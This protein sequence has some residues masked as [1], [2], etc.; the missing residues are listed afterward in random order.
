V[1]TVG[2]GQPVVERITFTAEGVELVG[3]LRL[4][5]R[6]HPVPAVALS[7]PFTGVKEQVVGL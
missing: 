1:I 7:G 3:H 4:P 2:S 5:D 6:E